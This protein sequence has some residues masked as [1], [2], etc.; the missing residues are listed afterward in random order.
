MFVFSCIVKTVNVLATVQ[1]S[2][3]QYLYMCY[4]LVNCVVGD[5]CQNDIPA[6][7]AEECHS[8]DSPAN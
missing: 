2:M 4:V 8:K 5:Q 6:A 3:E 7:E 1:P